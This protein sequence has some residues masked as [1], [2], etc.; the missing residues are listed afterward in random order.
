MYKRQVVLYIVRHL[1]PKHH[2]PD[3]VLFLRPPPLSTDVLD[4]LHAL[5]VDSLIARQKRTEA[6][7]GNKATFS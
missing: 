3:D 7:R 4:E 2:L 6:K 1:R 5:L